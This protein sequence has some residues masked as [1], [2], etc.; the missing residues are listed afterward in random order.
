MPDLTKNIVNIERSLKW[1]KTMLV[2]PDGSMGVYERYRI[3]SQTVNHWVRP[4]CTLEV[5]RLFMAYGQYKED[6]EYQN[7]AC[8]MADY[9]VSLQRSEGWFTGSFPFYKFVP[10]KL[11]EEDIGS[12]ESSLFAFPSDNGKVAEILL[13]FYKQTSDAKYARAADAVLNYLTRVQAPDGCFS[14]NDEG[15][16]ALLKGVDFV[17][18]PS[19]ALWQGAI[20]LDDNKY[21]DAGYKAMAWL[22]A[23]ITEDKRIRTIYETAGTGAWRPPSSDLAVAIKAYASSARYTQDFAIWNGMAFLASRLMSWQDKSG[24]IRNCDE[25]ARDASLQNDP[26]MTDMVYTNGYAML[27]LQ[28]AYLVNGNTNYRDAAERIA[29]FL[30]GVQ[31]WGESG[32]WDGSWRGSYHLQKKQWYGRANQENELDE[33][34]MYSSYTGM[35]TANIAYGLLRAILL[36]MPRTPN[37][38]KL[39]PQ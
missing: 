35:S 37:P 30:A 2:I 6:Q 18:W 26:D 36:R 10:V 13:W 5:A 8:R 11:E 16:V 34:G 24:A 9:V 31:C 19:V 32:A 33:G 7:V 20:I 29:E 12:P 15:D 25:S 39:T 1:L 21:H 22:S 3:D 28:E 4:D 17:A 27:A 14:L 38:I 23:Q